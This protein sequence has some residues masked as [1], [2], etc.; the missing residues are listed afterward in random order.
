MVLGPLTRAVSPYPFLDLTRHF[1]HLGMDRRTAERYAEG[2][3]QGWCV[4]CIEGR[5]DC[6]WQ[7][8]PLRHAAAF[9]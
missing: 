5:G 1:V 9:P 7:R 4:I 3:A 8:F 6:E 2:I